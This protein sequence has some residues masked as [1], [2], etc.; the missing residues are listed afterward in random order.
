MTTSL[1]TGG[2]GFIGSHI[3]E[4][5]LTLGHNVKVLDNLST[6]YKKNLE[7][8]FSDI[9]FIEEDFRNLDAIRPAFKGVD[10]VFH[11]GALPSVPRS[12]DDP[13]TTNDCNVVGTL[14][15]LLAAR[16]A[17]VKRVMYAASSSAYGD[18]DVDVKVETLL[19]KPLSPYATSKLA[20]EQYC[21]N[22]Y[23]VYGLE[24][25]CLRYFNVFG[26]RQD[27]ASQYSGVIAKFVDTMARG[28]R[29]T[30][31]GDG[32]QSRDFT[33]VA[34]NVDANIKA[35][36]AGKVACG[37]TLN[38]ACGTNLNLNDLVKNINV[39]LGTSIEPIYDEPRKGDV[40]HSLAGINKAQKLLG[41]EPAI[42][43][44]DGLARYVSWVQKNLNRS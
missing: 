37:E 39:I 12:V 28:E 6:G 42:S 4:K 8:V 40:K 13:V 9:E 33:Y 44:A 32:T 10:F 24:T 34:N 2:A 31:H 38:I 20:G 22:F 27:P 5:L 15:V 41:Y 18:Q 17:G 23:I 30:I 1:V 3:V 26:E 21:K 19:E 35:A 29:P 14:N 16:D 7:T 36:E 11:Q 25:I 43:V